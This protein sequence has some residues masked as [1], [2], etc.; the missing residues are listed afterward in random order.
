MKD[1]FIY[2]LVGAAAVLIVTSLLISQ[3]KLYGG[4]TSNEK[5]TV[6]S[7]ISTLPEGRTIELKDSSKCNDVNIFYEGKYSGE[8]KDYI[9]SLG[10]GRKRSGEINDLN[11]YNI[12]SPKVID[13]GQTGVGNLNTIYVKSNSNEIFVVEVNDTFYE[14]E[15]QSIKD[16]KCNELQPVIQH[17]VRSLLNS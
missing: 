15:N 6:A 9:R 14:P 1:K 3:K 2:F 8:V 10:Y 13:L 12:N 5:G 7:L 4:K 11:T 17:L 16:Y